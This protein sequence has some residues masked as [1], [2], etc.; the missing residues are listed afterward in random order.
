[1]IIGGD[2]ITGQ[3]CELDRIPHI[4]VA[5][6]GRL[7]YLFKECRESLKFVENAKFLVLD[8]LDQLLNDSIIPDVKDIISFLPKEKQTL[9]FSATINYKVHTNPFFSQL[10]VGNKPQLIDLTQ[11][12]S[13]QEKTVKELT[14]KFILIP[15]KT[16]ELYLFHLLKAVFPNKYT[17][18]FVKTCLKCHFIA[19]LLEKF[20][21]KVSKI[22]S[23]IPQRVRFKAIEY[24]K[25]RTNNILIS[26]D[27]ASR[28]LDI[29]LV[30]L[31][32][33]YDITRNPY[34][35]IHRV[36][37]TARAGNL[38]LAISFV[39]QYDVSLILEIE[40]TI[41]KKLEELVIEDEDALKCLNLV[42]QASKIVKLNI[43]ESGIEDK[44]SERKEKT[45][46]RKKQKQII[47]LNK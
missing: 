3:L 47:E 1:M 21:F 7:N 32:I 2:D 15:R 40:N 13:T 22:H 9:F 4:I 43:F 36:G 45:L 35:Y 37:R 30:D 12:N 16:K 10:Y 23:K 25:S 19:S 31:V 20:D 38:G 33:N 17:I 24:F 8:E 39:T 27:L 11:D 34:D 14:Q 28:G 6:P 42:S 41:N 44:I 26:T 29:P 5:T 18:I 46:S